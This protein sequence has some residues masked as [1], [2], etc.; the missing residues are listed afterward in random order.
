MVLIKSAFFVFGEI[1]EPLGVVYETQA[2]DVVSLFHHFFP[3]P[4]SFFL[5]PIPW[6]PFLEFIFPHGDRRLIV[7]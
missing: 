7:V 1:I 6:H 4:P 5:V 2:C 3:T